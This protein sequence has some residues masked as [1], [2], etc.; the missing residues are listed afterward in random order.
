MFQITS[1]QGP[2]W[3][4]LRNRIETL[5]DE[6]LYTRDSNNII[7]TTRESNDGRNISIKQ[8]CFLVFLSFPS[9]MFSVFEVLIQNGRIRSRL[10]F[11][12]IV[13]MQVLKHN[14]RKPKYRCHRKLYSQEV[15]EVIHT[16]HTTYNKT[17][18]YISRTLTLVALWVSCYI[19]VNQ[20]EQI[21]WFEWVSEWNAIMHRIMC[22]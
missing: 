2:H 21:F 7:T 19:K 3:L 18:T 15:E 5:Y 12:H 16:A 20:N 8:C 6:R 11:S 9:F 1:H 13:L 17:P 10:T 14:T 4:S 22:W